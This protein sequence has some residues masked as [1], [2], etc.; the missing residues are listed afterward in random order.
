MNI[1]SLLDTA[2]DRSVVLG[3][4][5]PGLEVRR[6]LPNWPPDPPRLDGRNV[7]V[8]G[9]AGGIGLAAA[10]GFARLGATVHA[11][12]RDERRAADAQ[13]RILEEVPGGEVRP[14]GCDLGSLG[15]IRSLAT[16]FVETVGRLDVLVNNAGLMPQQRTLSAD[17]VE[18][19]FAIHV[20]A[21]FALV[22]WL[23]PALTR[24]APARVINVS[25]GGMYTAG[26]P[27]EP[28]VPQQG[29]SPRRGYAQTKR[30]EVALSQEMALRLAPEGIHVHSMHP[31][32]VDT[33][34]LR[35]SMPSF[36]S[37]VRT[38]IRTPEQGADTI[39][40]LGGAPEGAAS[41]GAFWHDRRPRP[42]SL[43]LGPG[44]GDAAGRQRLWRYCAS[45]LERV[46]AGADAGL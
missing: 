31:G 4:G 22:H 40:W 25:S 9:A 27:H 13:A 8:T 29:Y 17:G 26:L 39:V 32:W 20:L 21:P 45:L 42:L 43:R 33:E 5:R 44:E 36:R 19:M 23:T 46:Q 28:E 24:A 38:I 41:S 11:L 18:L 15:E 2:L 34:G 6:R 35:R 30:E 10:I 3:Y 37:A 12:A 1:T 14:L 7:L 16:G